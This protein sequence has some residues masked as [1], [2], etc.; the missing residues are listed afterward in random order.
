MRRRGTTSGNTRGRSRSWSRAH[1]SGRAGRACRRPLCSVLVQ[2]LQPASPTR[3][4][5]NS[6]RPSATPRRGAGEAGLRPVIPS[7][8]PLSPT[9]NRPAR[10]R[11]Q[12][13]VLYWR[14]ECRLPTLTTFSAHTKRLRWTRQLLLM[15]LDE[16]HVD[17]LFEDLVGNPATLKRAQYPH[18][19][20]VALAL[21]HSWRADDLAE[22]IEQL[23]IKTL[24]TH[25][26]RGTRGR[27]RRRQEN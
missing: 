5:G 27:N 11:R 24:T 21:R 19:I 10:S 18:A 6:Y 26:E 4:G 9:Q 22:V 25:G 7:R 20:A 16:L 12:R 3:S 14:S 2:R 13:S 15:L 17:D 8:K 23:G 1:G